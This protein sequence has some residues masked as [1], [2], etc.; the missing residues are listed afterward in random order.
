MVTAM[1]TTLAPRMTTELCPHGRTYNSGCKCETCKRN[2]A[3]YKRVARK[4]KAEQA[5]GIKHPEDLV[6]AMPV[7]RALENATSMGIPLVE[8]ASATGLQRST[9]QKILSEG[10]K[11]VQRQ[12]HDPIM[13]LYG[14]PTTVT[15]YIDDTR[16]VPSKLYRWKMEA[17][18]A[19]GWT[20]EM[21]NKMLRDNGRPSGWT[22]HV[23][24]SKSRTLVY[25]TAMHVDWLVEQIGDRHGPSTLN[26]KRMLARDVYPLFHYTEDGKLIRKSITEE[27]K[28]E[29]RRLRSDHGAATG[30]SDGTSPLPVRGGGSRPRGRAA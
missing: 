30:S 24:T 1:V 12:V 18:L 16:L 13:R 3:K 17:L 28:L 19:Q 6:D 5:W 26:K 8:V 27:Q 4:R 11:R 9:V 14:D 23:T 22:R 7:I 15:R 2:I 29:R 20:W 21:I 25:R 10:R